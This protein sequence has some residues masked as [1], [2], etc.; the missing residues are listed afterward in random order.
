MYLSRCDLI[1]IDVEGM[2]CDVLEGARHTIG[3]HSPALFVENNS[4]ERSSSVLRV[5][6]SLNY[7]AY[8]HF[9]RL[10]RECN[11]FGNPVNVFPNVGEV[12]ILCFPRTQSVDIRGLPMVQGTDDNWQ[13]AYQRIAPVA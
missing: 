5:I 3:Q 9:G 8:W 12:N 13:L 7:A 11:Y 6:E 10:Y 1:K 2:E 4:V